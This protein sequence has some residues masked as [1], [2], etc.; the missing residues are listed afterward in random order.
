MSDEKI[1]WTTCKLSEFGEK[2]P[3]GGYDV[4]GIEGS[5]VITFERVE[6]H[7]NRMRSRID[8]ERALKAAN[9]IARNIGF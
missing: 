6:D 4:H 3:E 7:L 2:Y 8:N 1:I 5:D 9:R